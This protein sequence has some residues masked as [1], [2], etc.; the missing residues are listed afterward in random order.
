MNVRNRLKTKF[1][2]WL[3]E[4]FCCYRKMVTKEQRVV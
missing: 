4:C 3:I 2:K 1:S